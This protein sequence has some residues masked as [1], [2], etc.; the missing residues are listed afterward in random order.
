MNGSRFF[1]GRSHRT[2]GAVIPAVLA[3][4]VGDTHRAV[5]N[6][7]RFGVAWRRWRGGEHR[8]GRTVFADVVL[9]APSKGRD[10]RG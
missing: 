8:L 5:D 7:P 4:S 1:L 2:S 6:S 3:A 9:H 10:C